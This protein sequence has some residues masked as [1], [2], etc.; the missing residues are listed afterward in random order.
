MQPMRAITTFDFDLAKIPDPKGDLDDGQGSACSVCGFTPV[1]IANQA[2]MRGVA[3]AATYGKTVVLAD[4]PNHRVLIWRDSSSPKP[5]VVLG[6]SGSAASIS[7]NTLVD[8][9]SV[10]FDGKRLF[11]G[12]AALHRVLVWNNLPVADDQPA[13]AVLGQLDF[14]AAYER[15][16]GCQYSA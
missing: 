6:R 15:G 2:V 7:A 11:V 10:A 8:P 9:T 13:D 3:V 5:D 14:S 12:D 16:A 1:S 4:P